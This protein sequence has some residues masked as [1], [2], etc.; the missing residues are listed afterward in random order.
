MKKYTIKK[1]GGKVIASGSRSCVVQPNIPC[2]NKSK[3]KFKRRNKNFASKIIFPPHKK[4]YIYRPRGEQAVNRKISLIKGHEDWTVL[5]QDYCEAPPFNIALK[6]DSDILN[7]MD[8]FDLTSVSSAFDNASMLVGK[9]GGQTL[10]NHFNTIFSHCPNDYPDIYCHKNKKIK[11]IK[12]FDSS[13]YEFML[14]FRNLLKGF[15][16]LKEFNII[17]LDIKGLNILF[18]EKDPLFLP[19]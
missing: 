7:C 16:I 5:M 14:S 3:S 11:H 9:H 1:K 4:K 2:K 19:K 13:F 18:H 6:Y 12:Q 17:H 10:E 8:N 15:N